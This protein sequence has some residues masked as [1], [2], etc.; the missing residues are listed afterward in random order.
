MFDRFT[1][2]ARKCMGLARQNAQCFNH[3]YIGSEHMML[4]I[5]EE[6]SGVA[7]DALR[8][9]DITYETA[10]KA[11]LEVTGYG[12]T[13]VSMGQLPFTPRMKMTLEAAS[14]A[15]NRLRHNY[16]GT[17]HLLLGIVAVPDN[18][19]IKVLGHL[20]TSVDAVRAE[21]LEMM[22]AT[23]EQL[24]TPRPP[25]SHVEIKSPEEFVD[26]TDHTNTVLST[27]TFDRYQ[28]FTR[29]T[30]VYPGR[31]VACFDSATYCTLGLTGEAGEVAEKMKKRFRLGGPE[32]FLPGSVVIYE[33]TG[34]TETYE[35]FVE[36]V[37]KELGDV[38][39]YVA[40]LSAELGLKLSDV[41]GGNI[42]KLSSRKKRG[43]L[44]GKGDDR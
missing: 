27:H 24:N 33:K 4:G 34:E 26:Y 39:W 17:E 10:A 15:A 21:I 38:L 12:P 42:E 19:A 23:I 37:K 2:R 8:N 14:E 9:L 3:Q 11:T 41:A 44:K 5:I 31:G 36:A 18:A 40:G 13:M 32:A 25:D 43:V 6:R 16:I 29:S 1:D 20:G 7:A 28:E 35:Q 22:G 30:A